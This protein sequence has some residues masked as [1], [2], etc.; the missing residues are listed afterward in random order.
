M[1]VADDCAKDSTHRHHRKPG[2]MHRDEGEP[3]RD[4]PTKK[5]VAFFLGSR[6]RRAGR[7][8]LGGQG[9]YRVLPSSFHPS[10]SRLRGPPK[11]GQA[12]QLKRFLASLP[13]VSD[14]VIGA[15]DQLE[16]F[17]FLRRH[18][19]SGRRWRLRMCSG[20]AQ[21]RTPLPLHGVA[22]DPRPLTAARR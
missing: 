20:V 6:A 15:R 13:P 10:F 2:A 4:S 7:S 3:H 14:V 16:T 5:A 19:M 11:V 9:S 12:S 21:R 1:G 8:T 22:V 18:F 17:A